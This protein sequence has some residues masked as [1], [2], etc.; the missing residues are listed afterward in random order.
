LPV[1]TPLAFESDDDTVRLGRMTE[2]VA[3][4]DG[5]EVPVGQKLLMVDDEEIPILEVRE[6]T[7]TSA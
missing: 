1:L 3:T 7:V 2:W 6:L 5:L 4:D